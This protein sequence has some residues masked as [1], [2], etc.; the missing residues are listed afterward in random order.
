VAQLCQ[1]QDQFEQLDTE[2]LII[3]FSAL[4]LARAWLEETC[5]PFR[6][7][8]DPDRQVYDAYGM[9]RSYRQSWNIKTVSAY[10]N[11][12]RD[13]REWRGI[14]GDSAQLG[15]DFVID[16]GGLV[17]MACRSKDPTDRPPVHDLLKTLRQLDPQCE[18]RRDNERI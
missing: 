12:I 8:L 16:C 2:V 1:R 10:V 13:G 5:S 15:G 17:R 3:S 14:Q 4:P 6:L 7:L 9:E 11:L 18:H